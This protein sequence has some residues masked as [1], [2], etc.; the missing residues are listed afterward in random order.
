ME[1]FV[2]IFGLLYVSFIIIC[3]IGKPKFDEEKKSETETEET[4]MIYQKDESQK[5]AFNTKNLIIL[6]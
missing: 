6:L 3:L 5:I 4:S 1:F 2:Q